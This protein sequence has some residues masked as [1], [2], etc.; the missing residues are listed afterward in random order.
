[1]KYKKGL[2]FL[3]LIICLFMIASV[4]A[5][6]GDDT[7]IQAGNETINEVIASEEIENQDSTGVVTSNEE[8]DPDEMGMSEENNLSVRS[9]SFKEL[10]DIINDAQEHEEIN[11]TNDYSLAYGGTTL[12][13]SKSITLNGNGHT[14][15]GGNLNRI[16]NINVKK[17]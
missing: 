15:D 8:N 17:Y 6:D 5:T 7:A 10:Q 2:I 4:S 14:L 16:M 9:H 3:C 13:I 11:L 1:M 12:D